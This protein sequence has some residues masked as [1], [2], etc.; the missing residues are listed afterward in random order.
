[1]QT[2]Y[3]S[4]VDAMTRLNGLSLGTISQRWTIHRFRV[5][6][7]NI[8]VEFDMPTVG[9]CRSFPKVGGGGCVFNCM[10]SIESLALIPVLE[11]S[12]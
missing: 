12:P 1:M 5:D 9:E 10:S 8:S 7:I 4:Q 6:W 11:T 3:P 2:V